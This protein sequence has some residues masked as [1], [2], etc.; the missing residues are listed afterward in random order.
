MKPSLKILS[1]QPLPPSLLSTVDVRWA[2]D[3]S[4][5][6][7]M[8]KQGVAE[9]SL[10]LKRPKIKELIPGGRIPGGF[11]LS[12]HLAASPSYLVAAAPVFG[13]TWR[14]LDR[15]DC[16][17]G[18][19]SSTEDIDVAGDRLLE[20]GIRRGPKKEYAPDGGIAW[21]GSLAKGLSDLKPI[22]F[23]RTG[24]GAKVM[25]AC[26]GFEIGG[27]RF[28]RD[29]TFVVVP[30]AQ[31]GLHW[32]DAQG[33]L[34]RVVDTAPLGLDADCAALKWEQ[35]LKLSASFP[36]QADWVNRRRTLDEILPL[37]EGPGLVVRS[38]QEGH[39]RW[40][41]KVLRPKGG[42]SSYLIPATPQSDLSHVRGDVRGERIVLLLFAFKRNGL[43]TETPRLLMAAAPRS[44]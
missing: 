17:K 12:T 1:D 44:Q 43:E 42:L 35:V 26:A 4:L 24:P 7:A 13:V 29:G 40:E 10:D 15:P 41:L 2:S 16:F 8:L 38:V 14:R 6:L 11:W 21:I 9:V 36:M 22:V 18:E 34:V 23:D 31:P 5:Y 28:L 39:V 33:K 25:D 27:V 3:S 19:F 30:G 20:L 37:P 32:F